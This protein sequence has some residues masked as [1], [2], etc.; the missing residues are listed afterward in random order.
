M[1][2]FRKLKDAR[3]RRGR[4][5][6]SRLEEAAHR[7]R[8]EATTQHLTERRKHREERIRAAVRRRAERQR[9]L[10]RGVGAALAWTGRR[11]R[12]VVNAIH[13]GLARIA[14]LTSRALFAAVRVPTAALASLLDL[15]V[16]LV[17]AARRRLGP[18]MAGIAAWAQKNVTPI[19]TTAAV[20]IAAG[21]GLAASQFL[22]YAGIAVGEPLYQDEAANVAPVPLTDLEKTG[23]AHYYAMLPL[24]IAAIALVVLTRRGRWRLGRAVALIGVVGLLVTLLIDRPQAL[25]AGPRADAYA[26]SEAKLLDGYWAQLVSSGLLV[27]FGPMLG[28]LV[29]RETGGDRNVRRRER[30]RRRLSG[31]K[32]NFFG[33]A[34]R[35]EARGLGT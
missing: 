7:T 34:R 1:K 13:R 5:G 31:R 19:N 21:V 2:P 9:K 18:V 4:E 11:L 30:A 14:P 28:E 35:R 15:V 26:G 12:P 27:L 8:L 20:G 24:A 6:R 17:G 25:D 3:S 22:D 29:R 32:K 16:E 23:S 10:E 33:A